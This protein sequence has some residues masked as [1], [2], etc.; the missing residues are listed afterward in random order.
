M[1][2]SKSCFVFCLWRGIAVVWKNEESAG[3]IVPTS[4]TSMEERGALFD[5]LER[6]ALEYIYLIS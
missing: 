3:E 1:E 6:R 5:A 4:N 2:E